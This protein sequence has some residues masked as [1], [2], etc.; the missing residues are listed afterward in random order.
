MHLLSLVAFHSSLEHDFCWN[1]W[2]FECEECCQGIGTVLSR[3]H[4]VVKATCE[5]CLKWI[6]HMV[7]TNNFVSNFII[8][9]RDIS[10]LA[11]IFTSTASE[12]YNSCKKSLTHWAWVKSSGIRQS[13]P[14]RVIAFVWKI[15]QPGHTRSWVSGDRI[16]HSL[17]PI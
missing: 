14:T 16:S 15:T 1:V 10:F 7:L 2:L 6:Y 17:V 9:P 4:Y 12:K 11:V 5:D 13:K 8:C 3:W